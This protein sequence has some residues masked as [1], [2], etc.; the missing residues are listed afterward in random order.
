MVYIRSITLVRTLFL[1][2]PRFACILI[3][4]MNTVSLLFF[5]LQ[6]LAH[7]AAFSWQVA[8]IKL[9]KLRFLLLVPLLVAVIGAYGATGIVFS[10]LQEEPVP[11]LL[12]FVPAQPHLFTK[13]YLTQEEIHFQ[14]QY[15]Q[16]LLVQQP[17]HRDILINVSHLYAALGDEKNAI[18]YWEQARKT[19]P[20]N[21]IF[22]N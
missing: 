11:V 17:S 14:L 20:N 21:A 2:F 3:H 6:L 8:K 19:D 4:V 13:E 5:E 10:T 12:E 16:E 7:I 18:Y 9:G 22:K 15:L 1:P